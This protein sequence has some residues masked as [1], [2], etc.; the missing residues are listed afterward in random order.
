[1]SVVRWLISVYIISRLF[2]SPLQWLLFSFLFLTWDL[3]FFCAGCSVSFCFIHVEIH[4]NSTRTELDITEHSGLCGTGILRFHLGHFRKPSR[5]NDWTLYFWFIY[6]LLYSTL[7]LLF[8]G[9]RNVNQA[10][11]LLQ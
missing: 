1:M 8:F 11:C 5:N 7:S 10:V 2:T 3:F 9:I 6:P 4:D